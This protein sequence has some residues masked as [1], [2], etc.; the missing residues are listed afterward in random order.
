MST[1]AR[2][3]GMIPRARMEQTGRP[4][5]SIA[6]R[7]SDVPKLSALVQAGM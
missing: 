7:A 3:T 1:C 5:A 2:S 6:D 4:I